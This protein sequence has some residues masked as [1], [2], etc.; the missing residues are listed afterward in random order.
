MTTAR[1]SSRAVTSSAASWSSRW[2]C[3]LSAFIFGRSSRMIPTAPSVSTRTN[4]PMAPSPFSNPSEASK[5]QATCTAG[6][7]KAD[8]PLRHDGRSGLSGPKVAGRL[9]LLVDVEAGDGQRLGA[10]LVLVDVDVGEDH[11][12]DG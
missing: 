9:L 3:T 1:I 7:I 11:R 2:T 10:Q 4:S 5:H 6:V 12:D 8:S